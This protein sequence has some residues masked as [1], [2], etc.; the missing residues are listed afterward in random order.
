M[1]NNINNFPKKNSNKNNNNKRQPKNPFSRVGRMIMLF[2]IVAFGFFL[3]SGSGGPEEI[4]W[5]QFKNTMLEDHEVAK[6]NIVN[7]ERAE[8]F[9]KKEALDQPQ[10]QDLEGSALS[11]SVPR[12]PHY[13]FTIG[14]VETFENKL[15]AATSDFSEE[16]MIPITYSSR[17]D[18]GENILSWLLPIGLI[19]GFWI[20]LSRGMRNKGT[21]SLFSMGKSKAKVYENESRPDVKFNDVAGLEEAKVEIQEV[22]SYLRN[23]KQYADLGAKIPKGIL[24]VGPPGTGKTLI[25]KAVAGEAEVPFLSISGSDFVE[26]F[27]GVGASRVRSLF[28][29]AKKLSPCIIFID[30]IDAIGRARR[31]TK[32][33]QSNDEQENTLNQMLQELDG[34]GT[35]SGVIVLAATNRQD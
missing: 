5:Q 16:E 27:V 34:F 7:K 12:G 8:V 14:S 23:R 28:E 32:S 17:M 3:F 10:F 26:M 35:N 18:W 20:L 1:K 6:I 2:L 4:T 31:K 29:Q 33:M 22:V 9:I 25:G 21:N 11:D 13:Y 19:I 24:L 30:E 15:D